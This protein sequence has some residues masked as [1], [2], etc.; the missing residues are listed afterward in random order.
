MTYL[1]LISTLCLKV[2]LVKPDNDF[3]AHRYNYDR[4]TSHKGFDLVVHIHVPRV[5]V[6]TDKNILKDSY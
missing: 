2:F 3:G 4:H 6:G 5:H 1:T